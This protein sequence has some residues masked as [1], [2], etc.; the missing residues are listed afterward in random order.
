MRKA[1]QHEITVDFK[2]QLYKGGY[3]LEPAGRWM[4]LTV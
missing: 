2:G 4:R 1:E 3:T